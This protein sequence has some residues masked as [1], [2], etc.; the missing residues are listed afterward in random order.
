ML[1]KQGF[2]KF[3]KVSNY[4]EMYFEPVVIKIKNIRLSWLFV[5]K[6]LLGYILSS[7]LVVR[8]IK[9]FGAAAISKDEYKRQQLYDL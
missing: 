9:S 2:S 8:T 1:E 3:N 5:D 4:E 7:G 6:K